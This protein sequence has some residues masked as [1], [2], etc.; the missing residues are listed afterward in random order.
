[1][2]VVAEPSPAAEAAPSGPTPQATP[3]SAPA[4]EL[5]P[6][7]R[8]RLEYLE[9]Q[10]QRW[11]QEQQQARLYDEARNYAKQLEEQGWLPEHAQE[12]ARYWARTRQLETQSNQMAKVQVAQILGGQYGVQADDL[13]GYATPQAMEAAAKSMGV[14][15]KRYSAMEARLKQLEMGQVRPQIYNTPGAGAGLQGVSN[16]NIDALWLQGRV[17]DADYQRFLDSQR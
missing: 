10:N 4:P 3:G 9:Q 14:R 17:S 6:H 13:M 8:Q 1:M 11:E 16:D 5:P 12:T 7:I 2:P 15:N